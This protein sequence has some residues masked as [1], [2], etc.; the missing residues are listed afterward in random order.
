M[1]LGEFSIP[2]QTTGTII[3]L[4]NVLTENKQL[5]NNTTLRPYTLLFEYLK[6]KISPY[7]YMLYK[8]P[9]YRDDQISI[10]CSY[11]IGTSC[12]SHLTS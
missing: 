2:I 8:Y 4:L 5:V 9:D 10:L 1:R 11:V 12:F 7:R 3:S 6:Q